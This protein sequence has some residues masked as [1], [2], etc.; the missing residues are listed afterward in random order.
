[1]AADILKMC[2]F[3]FELDSSHNNGPFT[4]RIFRLWRKKGSHVNLNLCTIVSDI[5][6]M[7]TRIS[8]WKKLFLTK[9][10]TQK[11]FRLCKTKLGGEGWGWGEMG[12]RHSTGASSV[13]YRHNFLVF[14][15]FFF[16]FDILR[17]RH[18]D[19]L[20]TSFGVFRG[21]EF[22]K[23]RILTSLLTLRVSCLSPWATQNFPAPLK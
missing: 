23:F 21:G 15:F 10:Q 7:C 22:S 4:L 20:R 1:M 12:N 6:K 8:K 16:L 18:N 17:I 19:H 11:F 14:F 13:S 5:L 9:L 2:P 3:L